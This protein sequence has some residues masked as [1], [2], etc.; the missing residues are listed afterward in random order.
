M[1]ETLKVLLWS[2]VPQLPLCRGCVD[3]RDLL[4]AGPPRRGGVTLGGLVAPL[5]EVLREFLDLV[6]FGGAVAGPRVNRTRPEVGAL[7]AR[8]LA[9]RVQVPDRCRRSDRSPSLRHVYATVL[10]AFLLTV[11]RSSDTG[12]P[13]LGR[14]SLGAECHARPSAALTYLS[15]KANKV[16]T[17]STWCVASFSSIFSSRTP[18]RKAVIIDA[19]EIHGMVPRTLVKREMK[20]RRVSLHAMLLIHAGEVR[21]ELRAELSPGLDGSWGEVHEPCPGWPGQGYMEVT[22]H[23]GIITPSR[24]DGGDVDLQEL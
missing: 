18:C 22:C 16:V 21:R 1:E 7:L 9:A 19:S 20:A 15:A 24:R 4:L 6:A 10:L 13:R 23:N 12:A 14:P 11:A 5:A 8:A 3:V 17:V 2:L